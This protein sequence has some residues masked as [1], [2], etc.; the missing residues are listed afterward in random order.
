MTEDH[1]KRY[2]FLCGPARQS[3]GYL[4]ECDRRIAIEPDRF[5]GRLK[6]GPAMVMAEWR[7][8]KRGLGLDSLSD[9]R[10]LQM[11]VSF[12]RSTSDWAQASQPPMQWFLTAGSG[13]KF[14]VVLWHGPSSV[15]IQRYGNTAV[16]C[17]GIVLAWDRLRVDCQQGETHNI[18]LQAHL[19][20]PPVG[21]SLVAITYLRRG[22]AGEGR[23][24]IKRH[25]LQMVSGTQR[26]FQ[27]MLK[28]DAVDLP[29]LYEVRV[30]VADAQGTVGSFRTLLLVQ[31]AATL[32]ARQYLLKCKAELA[33]LGQGQPLYE[34]VLEAHIEYCLLSLERSTGITQDFLQRLACFLRTR[35][36]VAGG[37]IETCV[38]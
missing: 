3:A 28:L 2:L 14:Q 21:N 31:E 7:L 15:P 25:V 11:C 24:Q 19:K 8:D 29:G 5:S 33:S 9:V 34:S 36:L 13:R 37:S 18:E 35:K 20:A 32:A 27:G 22:L 4:L 26:R 16:D 30:S 12:W 17:R 1:R 23:P 38:N 10:R 6:T